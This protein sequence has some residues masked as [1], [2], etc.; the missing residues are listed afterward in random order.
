MLSCWCQ[1]ILSA[2]LCTQTHIQSKRGCSSH[3]ESQSYCHPSRDRWA[4]FCWNSTLTSNLGSLLCPPWAERTQSQQSGSRSPLHKGHLGHRSDD[5]RQAIQMMLSESVQ[6]AI[7]TV[8]HVI[9]YL[10]VL[11]LWTVS[12]SGQKNLL[13]GVFQWLA[14]QFPTSAN[15]QE[16][17]WP[18]SSLLTAPSLQQQPH[19][20]HTSNTGFLQGDKGRR[21]G[22]KTKSWPK[23]YTGVTVSK[24]KNSTLLAKDTKVFGC[25]NLASMSC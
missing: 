9:N 15:I 19:S 14:K 17:L 1:Q 12:F 3:V 22:N 20:V 8:L 5:W 16:L 13:S 11:S 21:K 4:K 10:P 24:L 18:Q 23:G 7:N 6:G 2:Y 25:L